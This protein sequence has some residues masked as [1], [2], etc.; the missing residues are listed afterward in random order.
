M[1][2][3]SEA[4]FCLM[5]RA[6]HVEKSSPA[7]VGASSWGAEFVGSETRRPPEVRPA[8]GGSEGTLA[9]NRAASPQPEPQ[10]P[11]SGAAAPCPPDFATKADDLEAIKKAVDEAASVGGGLWLS[12]LFV[13]FYLAL[14]AGGVTHTDLF[15]ESPVKL[16]FLNV[17]LALLAFFF[18]APILFI[19][20]HAYTPC[21]SSC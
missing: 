8:A 20:V 10:P 6:T 13:L 12:Y 5:R 16:P 19:I 1:W 3:W 15:L 17:E 9:E 4:S 11:V 14:A 2:K 21:I 18:L 7:L